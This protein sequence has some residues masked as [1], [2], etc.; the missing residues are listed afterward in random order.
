MLLG[1]IIPA[2]SKQSCSSKDGSEGLL[3][4]WPQ[5][6]CRIFAT[7]IWEDHLNIRLSNFQVYACPQEA[8][9]LVYR[10]DLTMC[11]SFVPHLLVFNVCVCVHLRQSSSSGALL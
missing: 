10:S 8:R 11:D 2:N 6:L 3:E 1:A 5:S 4:L 9:N 7:W